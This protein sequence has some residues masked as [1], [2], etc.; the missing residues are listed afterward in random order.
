MHKAV[1]FVAA[2]AVAGCTL[3]PKYERPASPVANQFAD[4]GGNLAAA[5]QGWRSMFGDARLQALIGLALQSNRDL[6]VVA[7]QIEAT[8]ALYRIERAD[9]LPQVSAI[10]GGDLTSVP[11]LSRYR[12]G[13]S[14]SY[15]LDLFGRVRSL[16]DAALEEYLAS[17]EA[18]RAAHLALVGA[19]V[20]QY[21]VERQF[22]EQ[23]QIA[24]QTHASTRELFDLTKRMLDAGNRSELDM[25]AAEAQMQ[26][27]RAE[28]ARLVRLQTQAENALVLLVGQVLPAS[29]PAPQPLESQAIVADLAPGIPSDVL[30][31][32]PDV[33]AAEHVLRA[34]NANIGAARAAFFPTISLTGFA[35]F[36]SAALTGLFSGGT[37]LWAFAPQLSVPLFSGGRNV[38]NLDL[39]EVR[40]RIEVARY[41]RAIQVAFREVADALAARAGFEEQLAAQIARVEAEQ[42]RFNLSEQ[43]YRAGVE[44]HIIVLDAQRDLYAA[45]QQL[46]AVRVERLTNLADLYR[47]LGGGWRE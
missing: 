23:R 3:A 44:S 40:K 5:D 35:G 34:A 39:A 7:L 18:H 17:V 42:T 28:V 25:R 31:R 14:A 12:I 8:R 38:A 1:A 47:A 6:R 43:R 46:V 33:L 36:A 32:R 37:T 4:A 30:L 20:T 19:V 21:M 10:A 24:E 27:A 13:I 2:V 11:D 15:E 22:A 16:K 45:Q 9:L 41:E 29:L 26:G